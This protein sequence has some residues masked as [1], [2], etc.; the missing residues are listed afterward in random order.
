MKIQI[1]GK[2]TDIGESFSTYMKAELESTA[3]KY[4]SSP[5]DMHVF[6]EKK[7]HLF[8]IEITGHVCHG[9]DFVVKSQDYNPYTS[10]D[11]AISRMKSRLGRYKNRMKD[12]HHNKGV[13]KE[14]HVKKYVLD[15]IEKE[16]QT[17]HPSIIADLH[18]SVKTMSV[19]DAVME[20]DLRDEPV[21]IF[22]NVNNQQVNVVFRRA[23]GHI[24]WVDPSN[25]MSS[26]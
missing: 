24:S 4:F 2:H 20:L 17:N 10:F 5:I 14:D 9:V 13:S 26:E 7:G 11:G 6:V 8:Q 23:D 15:G 25:L 21:V 1:T 18:M 12:R 19:G 22:K 3:Q 16:E